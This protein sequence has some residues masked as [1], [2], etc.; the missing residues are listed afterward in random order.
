M[1]TNNPRFTLTIPVGLYKQ[2]KDYQAAH[3]IKSQAQAFLILLARG[4]EVEPDIKNASDF[5]GLTDEALLAISKNK[6]IQNAL[7]GLFSTGKQFEDT[8]FFTSSFMESIDRLSYV[9][10]LAEL[11]RADPE[12][13]KVFAD[14]WTENETELIELRKKTE[15]E[16]V[17]AFRDTLIS[18]AKQH[19]QG[20]ES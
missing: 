9:S 19:G 17:T 18:Y 2:L 1:P 12:N 15:Y 7:N 16:A 4:L 6:S 20:E 8:L 11:K 10:P 14:S 5:S 13:M 3:R